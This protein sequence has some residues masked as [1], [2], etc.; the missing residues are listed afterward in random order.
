MLYSEADSKTQAQAEDIEFLRKLPTIDRSFSENA[1]SEFHQHLDDLEKDAGSLTESEFVL[2]VAK[3]VALAD[4]GHT[5]VS[6][7][8][9]LKNRNRL[10]VRFYWFNN[11][12]HIVSAHEDQQ[13][14]LGKKVV[15]IGALPVHQAAKHV[16]QFFG[17]PENWRRYLST[18]IFESPELALASGLSTSS[19][20]ITITIESADGTTS[21]LD[22]MAIPGIP[23]QPFGGG[24]PWTILS[25]ESMP[26]DSGWKHVGDNWLNTPKRFKDSDQPYVFEELES[27][28]AAYIRFGLMLNYA[29]NNIDKFWQDTNQKMLNKKYKFIVLDL[30]NAPGGD[31][32]NSVHHVAALPDNLSDTGKLYVATSNATFS[33]A[34]VN[35]SVAKFHGQEKTIIIG[36]RVGDRDQFWAEGGFPFNL[37]HSGL[38]VSF[39]T[40]YHDW[41]NGCTGKHP[42][43]FSLNAEIEN[44]IDSL[45]PEV[46]LSYT[47]EEYSKGTNPILEYVKAQHS[48]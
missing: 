22:L 28:T 15:K 10:P 46:V 18:A 40:G 26:T 45:D 2:R 36:E 38:R 21:S 29:D 41:V 4:N 25:P 8:G 48:S 19:D 31:Y 12:L 17:G 1:L 6:L 16:N 30:R 7:R 37:P 11:D 34:I 33:A 44:P 39:A 27:G 14:L 43:C 9:L 5:N 20:A 42:Y 13:E 32:T 24:M 47:F 23:A 3:A 35:A